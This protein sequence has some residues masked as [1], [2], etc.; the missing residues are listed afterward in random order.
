[1]YVTTKKVQRN[2]LVITGSCHSPQCIIELHCSKFEWIARGKII[3]SCIDFLN[4]SVKDL[5]NIL[6]RLN[7]DS[8][9]YTV[10]IAEATHFLTQ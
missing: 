1:M 3:R 9:L 7:L 6:K 4:G 8:T 2:Q 5:V 10:K